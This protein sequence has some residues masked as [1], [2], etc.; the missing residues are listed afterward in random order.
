M[1]DPKSQ[2]TGGRR[3]SFNISD[4]VGNLFQ[5]C[6]AR[7]GR[8]NFVSGSRTT[9]PN[10]WL[11]C[12]ASNPLNDEG[13]HHRWATGLLFDNIKSRDINV[14]NR[15][16]SGTGHGWTS[17]QTL[18]WNVEA[19]RIICDSPS[20]AMNYVVGSVGQLTESRYSPEE[21]QCFVISHDE[22]VSPRSL[23]LAQLQDRLG[24]DAVHHVTT[25]EQ[26][27]GR[28]WRQLANWAG[29][30]L[31]ADAPTVNLSNA[32]DPD[33]DRGIQS[34]NVCCSLQ[35]GACGGSGCG[36]RPGGSSECCTGRIR[37]DN[38]SC[39]DGPAPCVIDTP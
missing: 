2:I 18:F 25:A 35:C 16:N 7:S 22:P 6:Y 31:L 19:Q 11:D 1:L 24:E 8:H 37:S 12:L 21:P 9:G 30:G 13:P 20:G 4:G 5:R 23:Y 34:G 29:E 26:R 14:Q 17:G 15:T 28:I 36:S 3:Y 33:C 39:S 10:V 32:P 27:S 38:S